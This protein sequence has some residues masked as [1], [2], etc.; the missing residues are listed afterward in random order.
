[1]INNPAANIADKPEIKGRYVL[2]QDEH[3][4]PPTLRV[5]PLPSGGYQ[6]S[7]AALPRHRSFYKRNTP[8]KEFWDK[9]DEAGLREHSEHIDPILE[10]QNGSHDAIAI[11]CSFTYGSG[12]PNKFA[13]PNI[14]KKSTGMK[15]LNAGMPGA[16]TSYS[17]SHLLFLLS[18]I[19]KESRPKIVYGL[20][21]E[22]YRYFGPVSNIDGSIGLSPWDIPFSEGEY[23]MWSPGNEYVTYKI[24]DLNGCSYELAAETAAWQN[25]LL[26][27]ALVAGLKLADIEFVFSTWQGGGQEVFRNLNYECYKD[28]LPRGR[29][30]YIVSTGSRARET[31][32]WIRDFRQHGARPFEQFGLDNELFCRHE[33]QSDEQN[34]LWDIGSDLGH[35]GVHDHIHFAEFFTNVEVTNDLLRS[36]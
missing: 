15:V 33:P 28:Q 10:V 16:A 14:I 5:H 4:Q 36:L 20:F 8:S 19:K 18:N 25:F 34:E 7:L 24:T 6:E 30:G 21:P 31:Y 9:R 35:P 22:M 23:K 3:P 26:L 11:G 1:M 29:D 17:A 13:W 27:D 12:V 2:G 32:Q